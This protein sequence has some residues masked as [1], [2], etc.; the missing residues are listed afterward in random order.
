M[1]C[2]EKNCN[3]EAHPDLVCAIGCFYCPECWLNLLPPGRNQWVGRSQDSI[4]YAALVKEPVHA[5]PTS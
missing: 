5:T 4:A 1:Q 2:H 3:H